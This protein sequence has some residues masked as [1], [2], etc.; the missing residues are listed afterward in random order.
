M[1]G[2]KARK[3]LSRKARFEVF[4]RDGFVC[5]YCGSHPPDVVLEV[6]HVIPVS[7]G[8]D[9]EM[10]NLVTS[11]FNCNRGKGD[12]GLEVVPKSLAQR[13]LEIREAEDQ[14]A[15][16]RE[17][18]QSRQDRIEAD[19]WRVADAL[20][21]NASE[22]GISRAYLRSIKMFNERLPLHE[23]LD[24]AEIA[25]ASKPFSESSR[26]KYFCGVCWNKIRRGTDG[27]HPHDKA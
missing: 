5:Q 13:G 14:L 9:D 11:C 22:D 19:M 6:D 2:R 21:D 17:I 15:G 20:I 4:K 18:V 25:R 23:V 1:K 7:D 24:A 16:Y 27:T 12:I 3:A 26:F 8:G 10:D